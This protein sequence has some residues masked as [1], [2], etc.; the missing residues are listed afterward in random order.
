MYRCYHRRVD[1]RVASVP[2]LE[3]IPGLVHG[4][5]RGAP[6]TGRDESRARLARALAGRGR[7]HLLAQVHGDRVV[8]APWDGCPE[9]DASVADAP[10]L[11]LGIETADCLPVLLVDPRRRA[12][13]AAHAG[14]RG[15]AAGIAARAVRALVARG[16]RPADLL[17]ALGPAIGACCYEVGEELREVFP[18]HLFRPGP[19]GRPHLD[20]RAANVDQLLEA[21]L[22]PAQVHHV[23]ECTSCRADL[24]PSWRRDGRAA[25]RMISFVGFARAGEA[26]G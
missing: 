18:A 17:A 10:G 6:A 5:E 26:G 13:A 2:A 21:G 25:G 3:A 16:S 4:F 9:G 8:E 24:Y 19:R 22:S 20:V 14:W 11:L 7:L 1:L 15:T 12:V 23:E